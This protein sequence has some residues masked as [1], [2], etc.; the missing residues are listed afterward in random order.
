V[1][2]DSLVWKRREVRLRVRTMSK[3]LTREQLQRI[4]DEAA[5][6]EPLPISACKPKSLG[7]IMKRLIGLAN[8]VLV[9]W[10]CCRVYWAEEANGDVFEAGIMFPIIP[11]TGWGYS[12]CPNYKWLGKHR[13]VALWRNQ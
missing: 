3:W 7:A 12:I 1:G 5:N 11:M 8:H 10:F 13:T 6:E 2:R 4:A 9:Q